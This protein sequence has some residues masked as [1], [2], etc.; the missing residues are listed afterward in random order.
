[1]HFL[2][3]FVFFFPSFIAVALTCTLS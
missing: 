1:L 3:P 2:F